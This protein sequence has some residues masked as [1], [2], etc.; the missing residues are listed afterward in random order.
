MPDF[1]QW[2]VPTPFTNVLFNPMAVDKAI[3]DNQSTLGNLD[4]NRQ[5]LG[6]EQAKLD[7][8]RAGNSVWA[9]GDTTGTAGATNGGGGDG[10]FL[11]A[12]AKI[13]SGDSN[14][15][16]QTDKDSKGLTVAQ[17]GNA[18]E[19]SQGH[20]Q[21]QTATWRDFAKQAGVDVNQYPNAMSAPRE[22]QARVASVIPFSRFGP[23]TQALM[24]QQFGDID[25]SQTVGT[26]AGLGPRVGPR[27]AGNVPMASADPNAPLPVPP[28]P[29]AVVPPPFNPN[30]GP[31]VA[32]A[33]PAGAPGSVPVVTPQAAPGVAP[34]DLTT[35]HS[36]RPTVYPPPVTTGQADD[37]N[38]A[39]VMQAAT[40]LLAMP[41]AEA[42]VAYGPTVRSLQAH[43]FAM[44]AP[45]TY[46]GHA[47][48]Q[49][50]VGGGD[51]TAAAVDPSRQ[52]MRLGGVAAAGDAAGPGLPAAPQ[53]NV[54]LDASGNPLQAPPPA[55]NRMMAGVGLPG[56]TIGLPTNG[57]AP[58]AA[59]T[60]PVTTAA[61]PT[62]APAPAQGK[63]PV[64]I[65]P[66]APSRAIDLAPTIQGGRFDGLTPNQANAV[67]S[68][69]LSL[70][71]TQEIAARVE[72]WR[73]QNL[74]NK[75]A[76]TSN[77][78]AQQQADFDRQKFY[79][80]QQEKTGWEQQPDGSVRNR[81]TGEIKWPPSPR[82]GPPT[83][84]PDGKPAIPAIGGAGGT[85][86]LPIPERPAT[87]AYDVQKEAYQKDQPE[88]TAAAEH[89][90]NA[91][92]S[93][94]RWQTMFDLA[95]KLSTGAGGATRAQ[96]ANM[97]ETAGLPGVAQTLIA[98]TSDGDAAAAQEFTKLA[99]QAAGADARADL[100]SRAGL[101]AIKLFQSA[102]PNVDLQRGANKGIIGMQLIAAQADADYNTAK[103]AHG[104]QQQDNFFNGGGYKPLSRFEQEW[105][106]QR[107]PQVYAAAM[108]AL[109]GLPPEKWAKGLSDDEYKR[110][111][112]V[113][114][115]ASPS[116]TVNAKSGPISMQ[117]QAG[118]GQ[119]SSP[120]AAPVSVK[121]PADAAAL[122]PGTPYT[123]PDGRRFVR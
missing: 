10:S 121:T 86:F 77:L 113:V 56:V 39:A 60:A 9:D 23:R 110:A 26:L 112:D 1:T 102:N 18:S 92:T 76:A 52:A 105:Q 69:A 80:E 43:G 63:P 36:G 16:S 82:F 6:I 62:A 59:A 21:I 90:Q 50:L 5:R 44:N 15:V 106:T 64:P 104:N 97:A 34:T 53:P 40:A 101:G 72:T 95:D 8:V 115:R 3:A 22:V 46:P 99:T 7:A 78:A 41:E 107:N 66:P 122:P 57:M 38:M 73:Q 79:L 58:P 31:R 109:A 71:P 13:E 42:A 48:L 45:P 27:V 117:P 29:P 91:R 103:L 47:A 49:S 19:I 100:G 123:T 35:G 75:Q 12:L 33:T 118:Q 17:G 4:I 94:I 68:M 11:G 83:V 111:L 84:G 114:S 37:P 108:G 2:N 87:A 70:V 81:Y 24:R 119:A 85:Q 93:Q 61:A 116:A 89:V 32:G 96:L 88:I 120:A 67:K 20:F 74:A 54:I 28:I 25:S 65:P 51:A 14:I 30:A 55:P 98:H